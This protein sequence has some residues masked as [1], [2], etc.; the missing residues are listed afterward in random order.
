MP[1]GRETRLDSDASSLAV[2]SSE[3]SVRESSDSIIG[4]NVTTD[5][6]NLEDRRAGDGLTSARDSAGLKPFQLRSSASDTMSE[7]LG[8]GRMSSVTKKV[9]TIATCRRSSERDI[10][11]SGSRRR[12]SLRRPS[13]SP[14]TGMVLRK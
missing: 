2:F 5:D 9:G 12:S 6:R 8:P 14:D 13:A 10:R 3:A 4:A 7:L 1:F 11:N